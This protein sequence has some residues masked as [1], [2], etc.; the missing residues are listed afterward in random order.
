MSIDPILANGAAVDL[1]HRG[2]SSQ[3]SSLLVQGLASIHSM[4]L[5]LNLQ[6]EGL[7]PALTNSGPL[8]FSLPQNSHSTESAGSTQSPY[9][10]TETSPLRAGLED[11]GPG[12][13]STPVSPA[14]GSPTSQELAI[15]DHDSD[16][17]GYYSRPFTIV[18][19]DQVIP[20]SLIGSC[21]AEMS[22]CILFNLALIRH[23]HGLKIGSSA[24]LQAALQ[25]YQQALE[26]LQ[27]AAMSASPTFSNSL[28]ERLVLLSA[29]HQNKSLIYMTFYDVVQAKQEIHWMGDA[30]EHLEIAVLT[31]RPAMI[32]ESTPTPLVEDLHFFRLQ[33]AF[34]RMYDFKFATA[35]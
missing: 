33:L 18:P 7:T 20:H 5:D 29:I 26:Q 22:S 31:S 1:M 35:A 8:S 12:E 19:F 32:G 27:M 2:Q 3:A 34:L 9:A 14:L 4:L 23:R 30:I 10:E 25:L 17:P 11:C 15:P 28:P 6:A 24:C 21:L 16:L 13:N